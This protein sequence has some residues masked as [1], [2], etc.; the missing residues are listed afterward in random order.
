MLISEY[1]KRTLRKR[2]NVAL[3]NNNIGVS[4]ENSGQTTS[5]GSGHTNRKTNSKGSVRTT[6]KG[7][8]R[9]PKAGKAGVKSNSKFEH[10]TI[11]VNPKGQLTCKN[12]KDRPVMD[13][14]NRI[15]RW[16]RDK[17]PDL[18]IEAGTIEKVVFSSRPICTAKRAT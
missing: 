8:V 3:K 14:K 2:L 7:S 6:R 13:N 18:F 5:T 4:L 1:G 16:L 15:V 17:V 10:S 12:V 9:T 11:V